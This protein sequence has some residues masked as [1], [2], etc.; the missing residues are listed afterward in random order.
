MIA[1]HPLDTAHHQA[2]KSFARFE[3]RKTTSGRSETLAG[4]SEIYTGKIRDVA[5]DTNYKRRINCTMANKAEVLDR[6][7]AN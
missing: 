5:I 7:Q 2:C 1:S 3:R 6:M 4:E